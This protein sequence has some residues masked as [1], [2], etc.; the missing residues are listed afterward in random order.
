MSCRC[1]LDSRI[2]AWYLG[3]DVAAI[4]PCCCIPR[5]LAKLSIVGSRGATTAPTPPAGCG[6]LSLVRS[7][8]NTLGNTVDGPDARHPVSLLDLVARIPTA[9]WVK[10]KSV[11]TDIPDSGET[12]T[13]R[14]M[15]G[16]ERCEGAVAGRFN[17]TSYYQYI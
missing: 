15:M 10:T 6:G 11:I 8:E 13:P 9:G 14:P 12:E 7:P 1:R 5:A 17:H 3:L 2:W 16:L 4:I